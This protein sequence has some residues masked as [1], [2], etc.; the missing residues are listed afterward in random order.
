MDMLCRTLTFCRYKWSN[1][2]SRKIAYQPP[3][4][5]A[6]QPGAIFRR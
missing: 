5:P 2:K 3:T 1:I 4:A 6:K